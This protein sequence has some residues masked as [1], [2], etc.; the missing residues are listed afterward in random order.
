MEDT[1]VAALPDLPF[2]FKFEISKAFIRDQ[3]IGIC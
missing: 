3:I 1:A 2:E